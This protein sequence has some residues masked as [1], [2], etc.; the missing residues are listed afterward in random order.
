[1][2]KNQPIG[3]MDSGVGG[4]SVLKE[5]LKLLPY[6]NFIYYGDSANAPY[7]TKS[8]AQIK[9]L[10]F[11][12]VEF[13]LKKQA[14]AI[15]IACNT[16]TSVAINEL[17]EHYRNIPIVGIEPAVK[18][19]AQLSHKEKIIIMATPM[20]LQR[21]KFFNLVKKHTEPHQVIPLACPGLVEFIEQGI[22][23]GPALQEFLQSLISPYSQENISVVVLG[24]TH[25]PFIKEQL[26]QLL[27]ANVQIIDGSYGTSLHLKRLLQDYNLL[28]ANMQPGN[29]EICNS[30]TD[31]RHIIELS[32]KLLN[33]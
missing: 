14:K 18:P 1:M 19:A 25:Y 6:E 9:E 4:L 26:A 7:G 11:A 30:L 22:T 24:C 17:R 12:A 23:K 32:H 2:S 21:E 31:S 27:P 10:T 3:F 16:A 13:L 15:V 29:L 5:A 28:A 33:T 20:T 8:N